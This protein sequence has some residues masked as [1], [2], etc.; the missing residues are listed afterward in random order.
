MEKQTKIF[1]QNKWKM[2]LFFLLSLAFVSAGYTSLEEDPFMGWFT[3]ILFGFSTVV[4]LLELITNI[5]Y[6]KLDEDGFE[7]KTLLF[8]R[9]TRWSDV[10]GF[11][12]ANFRGNK[13]IY[14]D[15]TDEYNAL[16]RAQRRFKFLLNT[17]G[18]VSVT[19]F[20]IKADTLLKLMIA[21]KRRSKRKIRF[22]SLQTVKKGKYP[23]VEK[24]R[25]D[26]LFK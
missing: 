12:L 4:C 21:Y 26:R 15:Y 6:L 3:T 24:P 17:S 18:G 11:W 19:F 25:T 7:V 16:R 2:F 20:K 13:A 8:R 1:K 9:N 23:H 5:S 14:F 22:R 10:N